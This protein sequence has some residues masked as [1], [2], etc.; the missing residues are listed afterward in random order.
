MIK[1]IISVFFAKSSVAILNLIILLVGTKQL[2]GDVWGQIS[3]FVLNLSIIHT[4]S[5]MFT[6]TSLVYFITKQ[7]LRKLYTAGLLW[8]IFCAAIISL[9]FYFLQNLSGELTLSTFVLSLLLSVNAFHQ[10]ILLAKEKVKLYNYLLVLQPLLLLFCLI[11]LINVCNNNSLSSYLVA[12]YFS[13]S[14]S[15]VVS[16]FFILKL[17]TTNTTVSNTIKLVDAFKNGFINQLGNLAHT[18]SNRFNFYLLGSTLLV[19]VYASATSLIESLWIIGG[20]ISPI[21]LTRVANHPIHSN[22]ARTTLALSKL[23]FIISSICVLLLYLIP[24]QV[25]E[26]VLGKDFSQTKNI[27]LLLSP[28]VLCI[29]F[30]TIQSHYFSALG[31]QTILLWANCCG[32]VSTLL[33]AWFFINRYGIYGACYSASLSYF[34]QALVLF[35]SFKTKNK[36]SIIEFFSL[37]SDLDFLRN[38]ENS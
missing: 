1:Q 7:P 33:T 26:F 5:E 11:I 34:V 20:S 25:F 13:L 27:M 12:L 32:F 10:V 14:F 4:F 28:G 19:G 15:L 24:T 30:S 18:L 35:V 8:S 6:G 38:N 2:G 21:V 36:F 3:L 37:K 9:I 29:S 23:S 31:K 17:P 16:I 22:N